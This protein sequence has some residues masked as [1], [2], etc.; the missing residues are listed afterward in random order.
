VTALSDEQVLQRFS[1]LRQFQRGG[2]RAPHK[3]LLILLAL[4]RLARGEERM[5]EFVEVEK[6]LKQ[7][8]EEFGPSVA[9]GAPQ[10]PF[11]HLHTDRDGG[12]WISPVRRAS[13]ID[14]QGRLRG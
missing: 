2:H 13:L 7:L 12:I 9:R 8:I 11:W 3:P 5:V 10:Y 1:E 4:G 6:P 14:R